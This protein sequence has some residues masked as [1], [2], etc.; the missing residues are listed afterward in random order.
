MVKTIR[1][2]QFKAIADSGDIVLD[3][4]NVFI[5]RNG[6]GKSS[7]IE[8]IELLSNTLEFDLNVAA[9]SFQRGRDVIHGWTR[10]R[11]EASLALTFDPGDV[12][13]GDVV[14]YEIGMSASL[15]GEVLEISTERLSVQAGEVTTEVIR[16]EDNVRFYRVPPTRISGK[17]KGQRVKSKPTTAGERD[18]SEWIRIDDSATPALKHVDK[19]FSQGG[20]ALRSF[21]DRV[22]TLRLSPAAVAAFA[23]KH[24]RREKKDLDP[25]GYQTAEL[26]AGLTED[27]RLAVIDKLRFVTSGFAELVS[28]NPRGPGDQRYFFVTEAIGTGIIEIPAWV[29]SEGTRRLTAILAVVLKDQPPPLLSIEEVENGFDPWTLR[30]ILEELVA[31][32][33]RGTQILLTTH[34]PHLMNLMPKEVFHFVTRSD[35]GAQFSRI[36]GEKSARGMLDHLGVGDAYVGDL[37]GNQ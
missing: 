15:E 30:F 27:E 16:T 25:A 3:P 1:L 7:V 14:S 36:S 22:V 4:L 28:H 18:G 32:S 11:D 20:H 6:S 10:E 5:G 35:G 33:E 8:F 21:L 24:R 17:L 13:A 31:C 29:L 34:S 37:M 2:K 26:L 19:L 23:P 12:S 9:A